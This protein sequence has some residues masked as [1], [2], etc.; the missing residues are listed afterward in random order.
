MLEQLRQQ[1]G[2][3]LKGQVRLRNPNTLQMVS[4]LFLLHL[5]VGESSFSQLTPLME[6][7]VTKTAAASKYKKGMKFREATWLQQGLAS[8]RPLHHTPTDCRPAEWLSTVWG[9][10]IL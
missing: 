1:L 6:R 2:P 4:V 10:P 3:L 7:A 9:S 8:K 5:F